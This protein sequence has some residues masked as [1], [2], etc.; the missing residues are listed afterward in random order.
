MDKRVLLIR[1]VAKYLACSERTVYRLISD[2]ELSA[3]RI[4]SS[5]RVTV[6]ALDLY[7]KNQISLFQQET[8]INY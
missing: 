7:K 6:E 2:G 5:L 4:R 3:F 1:E 8:G